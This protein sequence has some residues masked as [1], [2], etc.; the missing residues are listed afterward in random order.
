MTL[1]QIL[2]VPKKDLNVAVGPL[3]SVPSTGT[4]A[5]ITTGS[6][7]GFLATSKG[8]S[9]TAADA[10]LQASLTYV[11]GN[12]DGEGGTYAAGTWLFQLDAAALT[13]NLLST[14]FAGARPYLIVE[15][16]NDLRVAIPLTYASEEQ[17]VVDP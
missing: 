14:H 9:A 10:S 8:P 3:M 6:V 2:L 5:P 12:S 7:T 11:G 13:P 17:A 4:K 15:R 16:T 1:A